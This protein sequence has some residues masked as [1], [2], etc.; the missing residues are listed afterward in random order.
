MGNRTRRLLGSVEQVFF[1]G[2]ELAV[3]SSPAFA[4]LLVL[5]ERYPDAIPIAGLLAIA[6]GIVALAALRTKTVDTGMWPRRSELTS[7]PLRVSYFSVLFL[8][9]TLGVAAVAIELG[10]L[11][12]ALAGGVVQPLGLAGFPRVYRAVYGDPLRKPAARM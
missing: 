11:W 10:T 1:G 5:Q 9:A 12:V 2:M 3:L 4:A 8:A 7:I 6:T